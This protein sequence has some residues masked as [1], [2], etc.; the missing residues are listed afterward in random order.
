MHAPGLTR[1]STQYAWR[2]VDYIVYHTHSGHP[3][4]NDPHLALFVGQGQGIRT[5]RTIRTVPKVLFFFEYRNKT[6]RYKYRKL[7][8]H[9]LHLS[10]KLCRKNLELVIPMR[11]ARSSPMRY[12]RSLHSL[13]SKTVI[14]VSFYGSTY[15][16]N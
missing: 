5:I 12:A 15:Y 11:Y 16:S 1:Q 3:D 2:A 9:G 10:K 13:P 8:T 4:H 7:V 6:C 14:H